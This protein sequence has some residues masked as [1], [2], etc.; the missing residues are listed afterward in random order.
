MATRTTNLQKKH[1]YIIYR[2]LA[3]NRFYMECQDN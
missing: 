1:I 3:L 2:L